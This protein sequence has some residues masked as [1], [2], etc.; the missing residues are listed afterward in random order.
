MNTLF[1]KQPHKR[2]TSCPLGDTSRPSL[3]QLHSSNDLTDALGLIDLVDVKEGVQSGPA[4]EEIRPRSRH[5]RMF[6][7]SKR[8]ARGGDSKVE[9]PRVRKRPKSEYILPTQSGLASSEIRTTS[10]SCQPRSPSCINVLDLEMPDTPSGYQSMGQITA[11]VSPTS[12]NVNCDPATV[13]FEQAKRLERRLQ[14]EAV[15]VGASALAH[16]VITSVEDSGSMEASGIAL[17]VNGPE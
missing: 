4:Q 5:T 2:S 16:S 17:V 9:R 8:K 3:R 10:S 13:Y 15:R 12:F 7:L 6:S 11:A 14:S 1:A